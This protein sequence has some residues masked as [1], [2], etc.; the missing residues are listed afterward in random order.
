MRIMSH[1][2][3]LGLLRRDAWA[4]MELLRFC[5]HMRSRTV[6]SLR[7]SDIGW[8]GEWAAKRGGR[9]VS[10]VSVCEW[11]RRETIHKFCESRS[12]RTLRGE[13]SIWRTG[14]RLEW[15]GGLL[16]GSM[17]GGDCAR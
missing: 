5:C 14:P 17:L 3:A 15:N 2:E 11:R 9:E 13:Q 16:G 6:G 12:L 1:L 10:S 4:A 8:S 7:C